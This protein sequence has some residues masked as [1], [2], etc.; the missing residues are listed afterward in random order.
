MHSCEHCCTSF[1][2]KTLSTAM[3]VLDAHQDD[4]HDPELKKRYESIVQLLDRAGWSYPEGK[5]PCRFANMP[6][7]VR[8]LTSE[9]VKMWQKTH[10][11]RKAGD[12]ESIF[13]EEARTD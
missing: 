4:I 6:Q 12:D 10:F 11:P 5:G 13:A 1:D 3:K 7:D 8:A 2:C 9:L